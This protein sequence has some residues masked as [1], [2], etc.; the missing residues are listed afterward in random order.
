MDVEVRRL[1]DVADVRE[2][3]RVNVLAWRAA[4]G[5]ILPGEVLAGR[6]PDPSEERVRETFEAWREDRD[7]ILLADEDGAVRG[8]AYFRWGADTKAFVGEGEAGLKELYVH[9]DRWG[10]GIGTRLLEAGLERLPDGVQRVRLETLSANDR[11][12]R[13]YAARGFE[14]TGTTEVEI[15]GES[16]PSIVYTREL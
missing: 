15:A 11:A 2:A 1:E 13:F 8:Y 6:D 7:G 10:R 4:Y 16:Y 3:T 14:P 5:D 12:R 9:P